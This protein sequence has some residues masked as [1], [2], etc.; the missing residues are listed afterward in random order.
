MHL[1]AR[2]GFEDGF[3][4]RIDEGQC[5]T[6]RVDAGSM[7]AGIEDGT[8]RAVGGGAITVIL[9]GVTLICTGV[10]HSHDLANSRICERQS[11]PGLEQGCR[12]RKGPG[13]AGHRDSAN[14]RPVRC[15][16][17]RPVD[18]QPRTDTAAT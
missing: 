15:R 8:D 9:R 13:V 14:G 18:A 12:V 3:R 2:D 1:P 7:R 11:G 4:R 17:R 5:P 10:D 6:C 16:E